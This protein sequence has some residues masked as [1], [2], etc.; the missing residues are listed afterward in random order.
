MLAMVLALLAL[1]PLMVEAASRPSFFPSEEHQAAGRGWRA[2]SVPQKQRY[3]APGDHL[4]GG[5]P[6]PAFPKA[7][8]A[9][10]SHDQ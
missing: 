2:I 4:T 3:V 6:E 7:T 5:G 8:A 9:A 1:R 10:G